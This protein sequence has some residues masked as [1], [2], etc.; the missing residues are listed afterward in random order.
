M[1]RFPLP[2]TTFAADP[3]LQGSPPAKSSLL[4]HIDPDSAHLQA[5][6]GPASE[7]PPPSEI[8]HSFACSHVPQSIQNFRLSTGVGDQ[9]YKPLIQHVH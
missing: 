9:S 5:A 6:L 2:S 3:S 7:P 1:T 8:S 4:L